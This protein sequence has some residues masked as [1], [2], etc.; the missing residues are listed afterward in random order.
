MERQKQ[1]QRSCAARDQLSGLLD[2]RERLNTA[3]A[4]HQ[5]SVTSFLGATSIDRKSYG[6]AA[7]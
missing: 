2:D 5:A 7:I 1:W 4:E 6:A 3:R